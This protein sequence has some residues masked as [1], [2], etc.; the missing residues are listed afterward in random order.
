MI[1]LRIKTKKGNLYRKVGFQVHELK[2]GGMNFVD[3]FEENEV[4][5]TITHLEKSGRIGSVPA[6]RAASKSCQVALGTP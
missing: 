2:R 5:R 4:D 6:F 3:I 1:N